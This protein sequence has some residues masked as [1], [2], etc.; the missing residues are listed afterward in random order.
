MDPRRIGM[1]MAG[2]FRAGRMDALCTLI[3]GA[4]IGT[5]VADGT[6]YNDLDDLYYLMYLAAV[7]GVPSGSSINMLLHPHQV[8]K[9]RQDCR[10]EVGPN[11]WRTDLQELQNFKGAGHV[12]RVFGSLD[13]FQSNN[14]IDET[15]KYKGA[16][17]VAGGINYAIGS[18]SPIY[19]SML[20]QLVMSTA[21]VPMTVEMQAEPGKAQWK[22]Y[23]NAFDGNSVRE[24][25]R[26]WKFYG[27]ST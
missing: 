19:R 14:V 21:G 4:G 10:S 6:A 12:G 24:Q 25:G 9:I 8:D 15:S 11:G 17:W 5:S 18:D 26:T 3:K 1:T 22:L 7:A 13:L 16:A 23:G 2:S 27:K 20:G